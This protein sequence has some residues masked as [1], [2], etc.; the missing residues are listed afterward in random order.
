MA[1]RL[2]SVAGISSATIALTAGTVAPAFALE[3]APTAEA[4]EAPVSAVAAADTSAELSAETIHDLTDGYVIA[5]L[6]DN[7]APISYE[8][9]TEDDLAGLKVI[10]E[11]G[12]NTITV[13]GKDNAK[14]DRGDATQVIKDLG[15][16]GM[17]SGFWDSSDK[18]ILTV[19]PQGEIEAIGQGTATVSF[20]PARYDSVLKVF[21]PGDVTYTLDVTVE[22][23]EDATPAP[24][25][26][27]APV[28]E[29]TTAPATPAPAE[30]T[31]PVVEETTAPATPAPAE[32]TAPAPEETAAAPAP[33][34]TTAPAKAETPAPV[35]TEEAAPVAAPAPAE[36]QAA[37]AE[38]V[39]PA[40]DN[41]PVQAVA[42]EPAETSSLYPNC[43]AVWD[44]LG[45]PIKEGQE[46]YALDLDAD[47]DG[48]GCEQNPDYE[49]KEQPEPATNVAPVAAPVAAD[50][51]VDNSA[52]L[53]A[54]M[55]NPGE[56]GLYP[57]C[58]AV[59]VALG[60]PITTADAGYGL[61]LDSDGDGVGCENLA[62]GADSALY[63]SSSYS[64]GSFY[65]DT[66]YSDNG[67]YAADGTYYDNGYDELAYTGFSN[68]QL[69]L[70]GLSL[71]A[72]GGLVLG[73]ASM[74]YR[75]R[76]FA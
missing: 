48:T 12:L 54:N 37:P 17:I 62:N 29:E 11:K 6:D 24:A 39:A 38:E 58:D 36:T 18:N 57:N 5:K 53:L 33:A 26:T 43:R 23:A 61:N 66:T 28:I 32:T 45:G 75:G 73:G 64:D 71:A 51:T 30:T 1:S 25:E 19:S 13:G 16:K 69:A 67:Y 7:G 44:A 47:G 68:G 4:T 15:D 42:A 40:V 74:V 9:I 70:A 8:N 55:P 10:L 2:L 65:G 60:R 49:N 59:G 22:S 34:E 41:A 72:A 14:L 50:S 31:A 52:A 21:V 63:A 3:T 20:K 46:G 35:A 76:H 27:T 56:S